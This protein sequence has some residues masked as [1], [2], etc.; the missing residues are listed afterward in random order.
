[1]KTIQFFSDEYLESCKKMSSQQIIEFLEGF[2]V[3]FYLLAHTK[4][5]NGIVVDECYSADKLGHGL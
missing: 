5:K 4:N 3:N 2:R 1:M